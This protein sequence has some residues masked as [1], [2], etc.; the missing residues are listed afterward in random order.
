MRV[1]I[2]L[3]AIL[4]VMLLMGFGLRNVQAQTPVACPGIDFPIGWINM[5]VTSDPELAGS[6]V[7]YNAG[8]LGTVENFNNNVVAGLDWMYDD[9]Q[10]NLETNM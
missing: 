8:L 9:R 1:S 4:M 7:I 3:T 2:T 6:N 5:T 10:P